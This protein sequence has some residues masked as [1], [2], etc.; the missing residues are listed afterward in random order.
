MLHVD[1]LCSEIEEEKKISENKKEEVYS[2]E[3]I[4]KKENVSSS[5]HEIVLPE[6]ENET[7]DNET[8]EDGNEVK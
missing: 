6:N 3:L 1:V 7:I 5:K 4:H 2:K 8:N